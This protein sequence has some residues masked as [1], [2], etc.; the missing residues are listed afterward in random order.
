[1]GRITNPG[2]LAKFALDDKDGFF[3]EAV[4]KRLLHPIVLAKIVENSSGVANEIK[5]SIAAVKKAAPV[6]RF[7]M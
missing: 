7:G 1:I 5:E 4:A 2:F 6:S 3:Q